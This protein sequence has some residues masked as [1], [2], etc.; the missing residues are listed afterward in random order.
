[1]VAAALRARGVDA[2]R[3]REVGVTLVPRPNRVDAAVEWEDPAVALPG[4]AR[5]RVVADVVGAELVDLRRDVRLPEAVER[6]NRERASRRLVAG[7]VGG[8][9]AVGLGFLLA[10]RALRRAPHEDVPAGRMRLGRRGA[11]LVGAAGALLSIATAANG[12]DAVLTNWPTEQPWGVYLASAALTTV[13]AGAMF[14]GVLAGGWSLLDALRRRAALP[15][16]PPGGPAEALVAGLGLAGAPVLAGLLAE[17]FG[18]EVWP[19]VP[20][21]VLGERIAWL[22]QALD[23]ARALLVQPLGLIA[24]LA[25]LLG[26]RTTRGRLAVLALIA[27]GLTPVALG[28]RSVLPILAASVGG[29]AV[30][31]ALVQA[32]GRGSVATWGMAGLVGAAL[33]ALRELRTAGSTDDRVAAGVSLLLCGV[34]LAL[35]WR[36]IQRTTSGAEFSEFR[37]SFGMDPALTRADSHQ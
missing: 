1:A 23:P 20:A 24:V 30:A 18:P 15:W 35:A 10:V 33:S 17:R 4:G 2:A 21:T 28:D 27:L 3:W 9:A 5:A 25:I 6:A 11:L 7:S 36:L 22:A 19:A 31:A 26:A 32:F 12:V 37:D 14:G 34:L 13:L 8:L 29:V 16:A